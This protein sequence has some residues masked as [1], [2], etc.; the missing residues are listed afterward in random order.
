MRPVCPS[1][2]PADFRLSEKQGLS[3]ESH[4]SLE[5]RLASSNPRLAGLLVDPL[6]SDAVV[7]ELATG[8]HTFDFSEET[9]ALE[10]RLKEKGEKLHM[11]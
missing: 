11:M 7:V 10:Y 5:G 9:P 3:R 8:L 4:L 6:G 2:N 1:F